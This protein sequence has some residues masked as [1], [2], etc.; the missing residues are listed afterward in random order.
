MT[1]IAAIAALYLACFAF[2]HASKRRTAFDWVKGSLLREKMVRYVGWLAA[3]AGLAM[4]VA[5]RGWELGIPL[6]LAVFV[7]AGVSSLL[8]SGLWP[9][10]HLP[11]AIASFLVL[12]STG[13]L[14]V[15]GAV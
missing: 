4:L 8:I 6:W 9:R 14:V 15:G 13:A 11:S 3:I 7:L 5:A 10:L 1:V 2:Y 12:I